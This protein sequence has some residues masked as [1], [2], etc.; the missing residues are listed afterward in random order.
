MDLVAEWG[1][2]LGRTID[3]L[4]ERPD[5]DATRLAYLGSSMG[6]AAGVSAPLLVFEKR[7]RVA[8]LEVGGFTPSSSA[9]AAELAV[10]F[11][12]RLETPLI[13]LGGRYDYIFPFET[14]QKPF[15]ARLG[16][17]EEDKLHIVFD[18]GH[19]A[20]STA[21]H[22]N[23]V[24]QERQDWLDRYLER[25]QGVATS[26]ASASGASGGDSR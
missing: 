14:H 1:K 11:V 23:D 20:S 6:A 13:L 3:Y 7:L 5:I 4:E 15:I 12:E 22:R 26:A 10:A 16:T 17:P 24:I 25:V 19:W 9:W 18:T 2:D 21:V 8:V